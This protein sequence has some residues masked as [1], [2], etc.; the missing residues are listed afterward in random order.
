MDQEP[1][2]I[3]E[4][5][6]VPAAL[7]PDAVK[8]VRRLRRYGHEAYFV[9]GCVRDLSL[10][11]VPKDFDI[12]TSARPRQI[13]RL[14]RNSRIIGRRFKLVHVQFGSK[15]IEV[16]TFRQKPKPGQSDPDES[17]ADN[18]AED[19]ELEH[20]HDP[21]AEVDVG[22][23]DAAR[24][25]DGNG[26]GDAEPALNDG[27]DSDDDAGEGGS[28][29]D[30]LIR[31]DN[32][33]GT[34]EEDALR[35][36]F[37]INALF[38][39]VDD[40]VVIDYVGGTKDLEERVIRTIGDPLIRFPEDPVRILRAIKF[41]A[42]LSF[43]IDPATY[44]AMVQFAPDLQKCAAPR[45][46]EELLKLLSCGAAAAAFELLERT[47]VLGVVLPQLAEMLERG[48][49]ADEA[50]LDVRA[51][52]LRRLDALDQTDRGRRSFQNAV[53]L[54]TLFADLVREVLG[55]DEQ[56]DPGVL[57]DDAL[58]P[59][60]QRMSISRRDAFLIKQIVLAQSRLKKTKSGS[61]RRRVKPTDYVRRDYFE[62]A[63][64]F[65]RIE[66]IAYGLDAAHVRRWEDVLDQ[67]FGRRRRDRDDGRRFAAVAHDAE[68]SGPVE[69]DGES[70]E[71]SDAEGADDEANGDTDGVEAETDAGA[72]DADS[73]DARSEDASHRLESGAPGEHRGRRRRRRRGGRNRNRNREDRGPVDGPNAGAPQDGERAPSE[74]GEAAPASEFDDAARDD[75]GEVRE[76]V[77]VPG[78]GGAETRS[79]GGD[80]RREGGRRGRRR[81]GRGRGRDRDRADRA[82]DAAKPHDLDDQGSDDLDVAARDTAPV[83]DEA[84][85]EDDLFIDWDAPL[86][87]VGDPGPISVIRTGIDQTE[88][89]GRRKKR[90]FD[91][92]ARD[93]SKEIEDQPSLQAL[94][95][96]EGDP[97]GHEATRPQKARRPKDE[98][99]ELRVREKPFDFEVD[100]EAIEDVFRW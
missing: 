98:P 11:H 59:I 47:G 14:F 60:S 71:G 38:Y 90:R 95:M 70:G 55:A 52:L 32:V 91:S 82:T 7:D 97:R 99:I 74:D 28:D 16:S 100:F 67:V 1:L 23:T 19:F 54:T 17:S 46:A 66:T 31:R 58:R 94:K 44:E 12:A 26:S 3:N 85:A 86:P 80:D 43:H 22:A 75:D 18:G 64:A 33:F 87:K 24:G 37:T 42:R 56:R 2:R 79:S 84:A 36:D 34:A 27:D 61:R 8:I 68:D 89:K 13:K 96:T 93:L 78:E 53:Y 10:G 76:N 69:G 15:V 45:L 72:D 48:T 30:L 57:I 21:D 83:E 39:D 9:G 77:E 62:P 63:F 40:N 5:L 51:R 35:R 73:A 88:K 49:V 4:P 20:G 65:L 92:A 41:A 81:R 25:E 29:E 50:G 6:I